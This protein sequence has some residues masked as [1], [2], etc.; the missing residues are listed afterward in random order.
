M[1][2]RWLRRGPPAAVWMLGLCG[3]APA[4]AQELYALAGA[5]YTPGLE[6][7]SYSFMYEYLHNLNDHLFATF[8]WL[9]EGHVTNHHRDGLSGQIWARWLSPARRLALSAGVGPYRYY[10]TTYLESTGAVTDAHNWGVMYSAAAHW[11]F[12]AP[13]VLQLRYN[14]VHTTTSISTD[15]LLIG[16]GYQ[17][18]SA[19]HPGPV[20]AGSFGFA[21]AERNEVT[22]MAG[23]SIVNNFQ[24]PHGVAYGL[25]YRRRVTPFIDAT[26]T[27]LDEG[28]THVVKR[29]GVAGEGWLT[30]EFLDHRA[31]VGLGGGFYLARDEEAADTATRMLGLITMA[32]SYRFSARWSTRLYWDRT[33]TTDGRDSDVVLLG[34]G[35][36]F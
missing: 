9:N 22:L 4:M 28:D 35:Y 5:Q 10:D 19:S 33:I 36:A 25:E 31:A 27:L 17:F 16:I 2:A 30:R 24:S 34:L 1:R 13:W 7:T 23:N 29:K 26:V 12:R 3:A 18:E 32:L 20:R 14:Y 11:Y 6:E 8:N 15:T 21:G